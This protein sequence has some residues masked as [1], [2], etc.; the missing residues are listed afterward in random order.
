M[1]LV[2]TPEAESQELETTVRDEDQDEE[3]AGDREEALHARGDRGG[4]AEAQRHRLPERQLRLDV[5]VRDHDLLRAGLVRLAR[6][7]ELQGLALRDL[8]AGGLEP[9]LRHRELDRADLTRR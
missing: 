9:G 8:H 3:L 1:K 2:F 6:D 5:L 7:D 4:G